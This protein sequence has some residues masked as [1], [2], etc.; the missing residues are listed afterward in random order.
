MVEKVLCPY[1]TYSFISDFINGGRNGRRRF[2]PVGF[3][4]TPAGM[5][6][7]GFC[8]QQ[9]NFIGIDKLGR[10][11]QMAATRCRGCRDAAAGLGVRRQRPAT[12][13][14]LPNSL[15]FSFAIHF[16]LWVTS[17]NYISKHT[18]RDFSERVNVD[19][20]ADEKTNGF[21]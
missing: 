21:S 19:D 7:L 18:R 3:G 13:L 17:V 9:G 8:Q 10:Q 6:E 15:V 4:E 14:N 5:L 2:R 20:E 12:Q 1:G 11:V 16:L